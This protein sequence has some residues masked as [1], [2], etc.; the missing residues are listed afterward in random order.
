M[1][2]EMDE[3]RRNNIK[4]VIIG[5]IISTLIPLTIASIVEKNRYEDRIELL[6]KESQSRFDEIQV[7]LKKNGRA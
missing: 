4:N 6:S 5:A 3:K 1:S 7:N 2:Y